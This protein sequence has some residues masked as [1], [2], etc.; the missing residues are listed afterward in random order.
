MPRP[1]RNTYEGTEKPP[2]SYIA[3][4]FMAIQASEEKMLTL[5]EIYKFI[6]DKYPFY[7]KN[8]QRW[9][10]SLRHNLSFND[11][12][13]KIP[14]RSDRPG[15]GSYWALHPNSADMFDNGSL[16]RRRK[17]F[18]LMSQKVAAAAAAAA[19]ANGGKSSFSIDYLLKEEPD[20]ELD[21]EEVDDQGH[22]SMNE[23]DS[24]S[25][26]G[27]SIGPNHN[28]L[29]T[30]SHQ[31]HFGSH[32]HAASQLM[33][34]ANLLGCATSVNNNTNMNPLLQANLNINQRALNGLPIHPLQLAQVAA[35]ANQ[36]TV[37]AA[38]NNPFG[39]TQHRFAH[40]LAAAAAQLQSQTQQAQH[41]QRYQHQHQQL[42]Q[43]QPTAQ[44]SPANLNL[45]LSLNLGQSDS[46]MAAAAAAAAALSSNQQTGQQQQQQ[47]SQHPTSGSGSS[48]SITPP[49]QAG[50]R[51]LSSSTNSSAQPRS[52]SSG[53]GQSSSV[54]NNNAANLSQ[55]VDGNQS[56]AP[57]VEA[58]L[59]QLLARQQMATF[60]SL[61]LQLSPFFAAQQQY[62]QQQVLASRLAAAAAAAVAASGSPTATSG[63]PLQLELS[64]T[65]SIAGDSKSAAATNVMLNN[66]LQRQQQQHHLQLQQQQ[67]QLQAS[68]ALSRSVGQQRQASKQ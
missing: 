14:R 34:Q 21:E 22:L 51:S 23:D 19:A 18:K 44:S 28:E 10:N 66:H 7:R 17:R 62:Q 40:Q 20:E 11:C 26:T 65:M 46:L 48:N 47:V 54:A 68:L 53:S 32:S 25:E 6:M 15:K 55:L 41:Q 24:R 29:N 49:L 42:S 56:Q 3:L 38:S 2:F 64:P 39:A 43:S 59:Q 37:S 45:N 33:A 13:I 27:H 57:H 5:S 35:Q 16:L 31:D 67:L 60:Q 9:Q 4:T 61:M 30:T 50:G 1:G 12:F 52:P 36:P 63:A 58:A 8:T